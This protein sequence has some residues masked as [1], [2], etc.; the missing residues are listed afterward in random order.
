MQ[1]IQRHISNFKD[2]GPDV[3]L[4]KAQAKRPVLK[5]IVV[6]VTVMPACRYCKKVS[7][8][9]FIGCLHKTSP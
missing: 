1:N 9:E 7:S 5:V 3:G 2:P 6:A 4:D 8:I